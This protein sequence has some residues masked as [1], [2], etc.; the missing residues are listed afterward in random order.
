MILTGGLPLG[1]FT[2]VGTF[3]L[4]HQ[5][6]MTHLRVKEEVRGPLRGLLWKATPD[7]R[8]DLIDYVNAVKKRAEILG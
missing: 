7:T 4:D 6:G 8:Q 5:G 1:L 3:T 2:G